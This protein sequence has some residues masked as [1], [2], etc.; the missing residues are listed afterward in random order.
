MRKLIFIIT[1][2]SAIA[3]CQPRHPSDQAHDSASKALNNERSRKNAQEDAAQA[4][5]QLDLVAGRT[6]NNLQAIQPKDA[7]STPKK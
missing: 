2:V 1:A 6:R 7:R 3:A 4:Q 5:R